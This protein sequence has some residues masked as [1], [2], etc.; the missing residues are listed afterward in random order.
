MPRPYLAVVD[1]DGDEMGKW[2]S[3]THRNFPRFVNALHSKVRAA[4]EEKCPQVKERSQGLRPITP[5]FHAAFSAAAASFARIGAPLTIEGEDLPGHLVYAGGDDALFLASVP[6]TLEL[7]RRLRLRFSGHPQSFS[8][9]PRTD[10]ERDERA[11]S[12]WL[13]ACVGEYGKVWP[14]KSSSEVE[15]LGL[16]FGNGATASAGLCVFHYRWPLSSAL[17]AARQA[18]DEAKRGGRN[19]L[20]IVIQ[21]RSGSVTKCFLPFSATDA[22]RS[23]VEL[24]Q[25]LVEDFAQGRVSTRLASLFRAELAPL[26]GS[27]PTPG[28]A[29]GVSP[30]PE[31][32]WEVA[33]VLA[34]RV[35]TRR[36]VKERAAEKEA[37]GSNQR[38]VEHLLALGEAMR[39]NG[40]AS[41][42]KAEQAI[43]EW[44]E[45]VTA[46]AFLAREGE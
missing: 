20:G 4:L 35:A 24:L 15:R 34:K 16:A 28:A 33:C 43:V 14:A 11:H 5:A 45:V 19:R 41:M 38:I 17:R 31:E 36:E 7:V 1:F 6:E 25:A 23:P 44:S 27:R 46:A 30:T 29:K 18:L 42:E 8:A 12:P 37:G 3:G 40:F 2:L 10:G 13:A 26:L 32:L 9:K 21:R 22:G 39:G